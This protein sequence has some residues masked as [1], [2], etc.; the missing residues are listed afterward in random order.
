M[1]QK[2]LFEGQ[3]QGQGQGQGYFLVVSRVEMD[4]INSPKFNTPEFAQVF[5]RI[6]KKQNK[7]G[8]HHVRLLNKYLLSQFEEKIDSAQVDNISNLRTLSSSKF[9]DQIRFLTVQIPGNLHDVNDLHFISPVFLHNI[10][11]VNVVFREGHGYQLYIVK[12]T[13]SKPLLFRGV[14]FVNQNHNFQKNLII[15]AQFL[16]DVEIIDSNFDGIGLQLEQTNK[17]TVQ[18]C[19]FRNIPG[20]PAL[21]CWKT[22]NTTTIDNLHFFNCENGLNIGKC[23][24]LVSINKMCAEKCG[25]NGCRFY[26]IKNLNLN[27]VQIADCAA[28][29]RFHLTN[30]DIRNCNIIGFRKE[31]IYLRYSTVNFRHIFLKQ[32]DGIEG[33]LEKIRLGYGSTFTEIL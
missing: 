33:E 18:N 20:T 21:N 28:G 11:S 30:A 26:K 25:S 27:D 2:D 12:M 23:Q 9:A 5:K 22:L 17:I 8:Y 3:R 15:S 7:A 4:S 13:I 29:I 32:L 31:G 10:K 24:N 16:N 19:T 14:N 1:S 6:N